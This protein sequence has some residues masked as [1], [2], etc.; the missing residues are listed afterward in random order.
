[1]A[2]D[3]PKTLAGPGAWA[4]VSLFVLLVALFAFPLGWLSRTLDRRGGGYTGP[5]AGGIRGL[6]WL[7][8]LSGIAFAGLMGFAGYQASEVSEFTLLAGLAP[9]G[10]WVSWLSVAAGLLGVTAVVQAWRARAG[11][12]GAITST[13]IGVTLTGLAALSLAIFAFAWDLAPF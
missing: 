5:Q 8:A 7:A 10:G 12:G 6:A 13:R 9:L 1:M 2:A 11:R 3:D 4:G